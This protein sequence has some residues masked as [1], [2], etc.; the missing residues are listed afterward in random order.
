MWRRLRRRTL[1][2]SKPAIYPEQL[3][4]LLIC[5]GVIALGL[6]VA[7]RLVVG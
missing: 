2:P 4:L 6:Y 7:V 1:A 3:G 5:L